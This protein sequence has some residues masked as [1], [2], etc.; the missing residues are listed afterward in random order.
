MGKRK[1]GKYD[2]YAEEKA[3]DINCLWVGLHVGFRTKI[4]KQLYKYVQRTQ[5]NHV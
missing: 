2:L 3:I 1:T 5:K 4:S